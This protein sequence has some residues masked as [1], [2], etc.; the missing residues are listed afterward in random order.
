MP[1]TGDACYAAR[2]VLIHSFHK[3]ELVES[4]SEVHT[5]APADERADAPENVDAVDTD[6]TVAADA[7]TDDAPAEEPGAEGPAAAPEAEEAE[8]QAEAEAEVVEP[9]AA[10]PDVVDEAQA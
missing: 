3:G 8:A 4:I 5:D 6:T 7:A 10:A 9:E 2:F 1:G